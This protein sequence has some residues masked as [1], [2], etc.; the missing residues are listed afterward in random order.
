MS[1]VSNAI[2]LLNY[3]SL[4]EVVSLQELSDFL[5]ISERSVQRLRNELEDA[6][7]TV[8][9][10][11]GPGGGY[12]LAKNV[13]IHP[14]DFSSQ[15]RKQ[16]KH[17]LSILAN[18][19]GDNFG[20]SFLEALGNLSNQLE[21]SYWS[22]A[23]SFQSVRM[24]IDLELYQE[25]MST[26]EEAIA[27]QKRIQITY[28]KNYR[29]ERS[30]RFE[31][32]SLLVVNNMWY[33]SGYDQKNRFLNL[34]ISRIRQIIDLD[35][36]YRFDDE[37][38]KVRGISEF[39]YNINP[40]SAII[41]VENMDY[42]SEYI[43][44]DQQEIVWLDDHSFRLS[45]TFSNQLAFRKFVLGGGSNMTVLAPENER[46]WIIEESKKILKRYT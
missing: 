40:I 45:V 15:Q 14:Q 8:E 38:L 5:Q 11:K 43:W 1:R 27:G 24:N 19:Q 34:K 37:T 17:G 2:K 10:I 44:G 33:V 42:I 35:E 12:R 22:V 9:T 18:Q 29:E 23:P 7:Y 3:L 13:S 21:Y 41:M 31:P 6:G 32:Y 4:K 20:P 46:L 25:N 28:R 39:G 26:L 30:Y 36:N 16:L